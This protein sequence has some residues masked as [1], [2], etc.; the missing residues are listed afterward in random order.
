MPPRKA[1]PRNQN[2]PKIRW[3]GIARHAYGLGVE[4]RLKGLS[5]SDCPYDGEEPVDYSSAKKGQVLRDAWLDGYNRT[6]K[7]ADGGAS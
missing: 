5:R 3:R 1:D 2:Q 4:A 7:P 6:P